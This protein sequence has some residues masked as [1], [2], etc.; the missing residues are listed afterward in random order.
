MDDYITQFEELKKHIVVQNP[1]LSELYFVNSFLSGLKDEI[2]STLYLHKPH[3]LRDAREKERARECVLEAMEK[4]AKPSFKPS[5]NVSVATSREFSGYGEKYKGQ[6]S[7]GSK[8]E[9]KAVR[10][11]SYSDFR[12]RMNKGLC[13][14]CDEKY[15]PGHNCRNK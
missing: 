2:S 8:P 4:R 7:Q 1:N 3:S 11:L 15:V 5:A 9:P 10:R 6:S 13:V 14:H 12:D